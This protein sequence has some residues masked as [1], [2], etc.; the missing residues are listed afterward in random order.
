MHAQYVLRIKIDQ[1]ILVP[2]NLPRGRGK[3]E[4]KRYL[5]TPRIGVVTKHVF[6]IEDASF[7]MQRHLRA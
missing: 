4:R 7:S 2:S 3:L 5:S 1:I 6:G